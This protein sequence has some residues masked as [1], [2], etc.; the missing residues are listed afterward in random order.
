MY[1][2]GEGAPQSMDSAAR[3]YLEA[4]EQGHE[5]AAY[6]LAF[7]YLR[8]RGVPRKDFVQAYRWFGISAELGVG[9]AGTWRDK[10]R[11]K[12]TE[13]EITE[14]ERLIGEWGA[15]ESEE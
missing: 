10:I 14:A 15:K 11:K 12:M 13:Q 4:A 8:G 6:K 9:D 2:T 3:W 5:M 7:L 1:S